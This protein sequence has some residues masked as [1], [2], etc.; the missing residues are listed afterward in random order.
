MAAL[1]NTTPEGISQFRNTLRASRY[2]S[3]DNKPAQAGVLIEHDHDNPPLWDVWP[4]DR[5]WND[6]HEAETR[7]RTCSANEWAA[8]VWA[9]PTRH[10]PR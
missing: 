6:A 9:K 1:T 7:G 2:L 10:Q 4:I 5:R 3:P 8:L